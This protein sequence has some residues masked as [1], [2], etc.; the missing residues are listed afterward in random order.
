M[1]MKK[2]TLTLANIQSDMRKIAYTQVSNK[3]D[4]RMPYVILSLPVVIVSGVVWKSVWLSLAILALCVH[5]FVK[6]FV[7]AREY[8]LQREAIKNILDR[9]DVCI[10]VEKL[11]HIAEDTVYEPHP[12]RRRVHSTKTV[13][14][15]Y[16]TSGGRWRVPRGEHYEWSSGYRL[17]SKGLE[18]VSIMGDEFYYISLQ[19][20]H[21]IA[22]VYP[23][24]Y[25]EL[26][27]NLN[28]KGN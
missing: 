16:F 3:G 24:K 5:N 13:T 8:K 17:S 15:Y 1:I 6:Y 9:G 7:A 19:G 22:Y 20:F 25:F 23:C 26:D 21:E 28:T 4:W 14:F 27:K 2:E 10:S 18:N 11:S 12:G